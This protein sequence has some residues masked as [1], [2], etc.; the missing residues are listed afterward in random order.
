MRRVRVL[1]TAALL[2]ASVT[3]C[4]PCAGTANC[5]VSPRVSY[6]GKVIDFASGRGVAGVA[7]AFRRTGGASI[8]SDS[9]ATVT[10]GEGRF[11][12]RVGAAGGGDV[13]GELTVRP[14]A[15]LPG[16]TVPDVRLA[17]T[18]VGGGGG[19][20][21][22]FVTQPYVDYVAELL[23]RRSG[24]PLAYSSVTFTR[25]GGARLV[26]GDS[27]T[28][29]AGPDGW[30]HLTGPVV[31]LG[32]VIGDLAVKY[33]EFDRPLIVR[34][35]EL[36]VR[37][38][39]RLPTF[40]RSY[41]LGA[42][43]D[44]IAEFRSRGTST[45]IANAEV[46]F[47]RTGGLA[48]TS[49][50]FTGRTNADGRLLLSLVPASEAAGEVVGD[51]TVRPSSGEPPFTI[52]GVRVRTYDA[53]VVPFLGILN[54]GYQAVAVGE[55]QFRGDRAPLGGV[56]VV[57]ERTGG[58]DARPARVQSRTLPDGR[59]GLTLTTDE[60]GI[61]EGDLL[62][63]T[64]GAAAPTRIPGVRL[65]ARGDDSVRFLGRFGVGAQLLYV[66]QLA[67][68]ATGAAAV[69]W[70]VT[71]RRT[72]G[73]ALL[74]DTTSAV[75]VDWGGFSIAPDTRAEGEVVGELTARPPA[76]GAPV[77]LGT[78]RL[79]TR[80]DDSVRFAGRWN[81]GPSLLYVGELLRDN[82]TP[83]EGARVEFRRTGGLATAESLLV[84]RSNAVG[85]FRLAPTPLGTGEVVGELRVFP[86]APLRD[87]VI[88]NVT[89]PTFESDEVRLRAVWRLPVPR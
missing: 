20:L 47:R 70:T 75:S 51:V 38:V 76:G 73:I 74:R 72:G 87:T 89:L 58:A 86:P 79:R 16:Y 52:R 32:P 66:G 1:L 24:G 84:E 29:G 88:T 15:P 25:T 14:P 12:L 55:L 17:Q 39:D 9:L 49:P 61:V 7:V 6:S 71:F 62:V 21:P 67:Q 78:V 23:Y 56:D 31:G 3:A 59:F 18:T 27:V 63:Q 41:R 57:F 85:R 54:V 60:A 26:G 33:Y 42:A 4:D 46:E 69:G 81:V 83:I 30:F 65:A 53:D 44:Y 13:V 19:V 82:G 22:T 37:Y 35:V 64:P 8:A 48:L 43:L 40:D 50:S 11:E 80:A 28:T 34:G 2:G 77:P 36:P 5:R 45:P 10:D 68:R